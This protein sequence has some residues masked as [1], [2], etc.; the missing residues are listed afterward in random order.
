LSRFTPKRGIGPACEEAHRRNRAQRIAD[1][2]RRHFDRLG[3]W[4]HNA[5]DMALWQAQ[6]ATQAEGTAA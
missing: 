2:R 4:R 3:E 1:I 6:R 5:L